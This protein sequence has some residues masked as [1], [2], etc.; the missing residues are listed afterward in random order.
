MPIMKWK[1]KH[2]KIVAGV[3]EEE[4]KNGSTEIGNKY[5]PKG[6]NG[7]QLVVST[8]EHF[9]L[10]N[11]RTNILNEICTYRIQTVLCVLT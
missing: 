9:F 8:C 2:T 3:Y 1:K 11:I 6:E 7:S 5:F 4:G 10:Y